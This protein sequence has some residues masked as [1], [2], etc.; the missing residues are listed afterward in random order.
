MSIMLVKKLRYKIICGKLSFK[1]CI[2][3]LPKKE[4][5][6]IRKHTKW[7]FCLSGIV[8]GDFYFLLYACV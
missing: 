2:I 4:K 6:E 1:L 3:H 8:T 7:F 5:V